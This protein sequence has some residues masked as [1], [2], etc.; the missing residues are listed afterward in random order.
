MLLWV[1]ANKHAAV[2][3]Y[4]TTNGKAECLERLV[5][6]CTPKEGVVVI[7]AIERYAE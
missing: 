5:G 6:R 2:F 7:S 3:G 4:Y 1:I